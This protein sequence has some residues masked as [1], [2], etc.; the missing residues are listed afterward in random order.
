MDNHEEQLSLAKMEA[1]IY[2]KLTEK[3]NNNLTKIFFRRVLFVFKER[4]STRMV[5]LK[6]FLYI[7]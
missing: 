6:V 1:K 5:I 3:V 7:T 4:I 2:Q